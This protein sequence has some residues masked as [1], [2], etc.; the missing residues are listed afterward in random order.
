M[1]NLKSLLSNRLSLTQ[2]SS[3]ILSAFNK[4]RFANVSEM[5]AVTNH[6]DGEEYCT[7]KT[8]WV[9]TSTATPFSVNDGLYLKA[10]GD[11]YLSDF[12]DGVLS[13]G[14]MVSSAHT[15][16]THTNT[17]NRLV[18]DG[19]EVLTFTS[20]YSFEI[21]VGL[22]SWYCSQC[23]ILNWSSTPTAGYSVCVRGR[24]T[25]SQMGSIY[26]TI[27]NRMNHCPIEGFQI[28]TYSSAGVCIHTGDGL[29]IGNSNSQSSLTNAWQSSRFVIKRVSVYDFD[30]CMA[31]YP[32]VY[33]IELDHCHTMGGS[34]T[35]PLDAYNT[36]FGE[37]IKISHCFVADNHQ[38]KS[39]GEMG[40]VNLRSGEWEFDGGSF[41]NMRVTVDRSAV[42]RM[43]KP[44]FENPSSTAKNKR[45]LEVIGEHA[46]CVLDNPMIVIRDTPI[47]SNLFWAVEG[48][49]DA[50]AAEGHREH[51]YP[52]SAGLV[53]ISPQFQSRNQ[54]RPDMAGIIGTAL[55]VTYESDLSPALVGGGGRVYCV[56]GCYINSLYYSF[57]P[58]LIAPNLVGASLNNWDFS[59]GDVGSAPK[60]WI[61]DGA[62]SDPI[63]GSNSASA[64]IVDSESW[65]GGRCMRT[66][67]DYNGGVT[68]HSSF[69]YQDQLCSAG[70][71]FL[72]LA[73]VKWR[74]VDPNGDGNVS[75][76]IQVAI[77]FLDENKNVI[78]DA[79]WSEHWNVIGSSTSESIKGFL[80]EKTQIRYDTNGWQT[81]R[82]VAAAPDGTRYA[83]IGLVSYSS[84]D[85]AEKKIYTYWDQVCGNII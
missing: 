45:F 36:D 56:G 8:T 51:R 9:V 73:K 4:S 85:S 24:Y 72:A 42:V 6:I 48:S 62:Q 74:C 81:A 82:L 83:R 33:A 44:H 75:G 76:Y 11:V 79:S 21:I 43:S 15:Y 16:I 41:D 80:E 2:L 13:H 17:R 84:S 69:V 64:V 63:N 29:R 46:Y 12:D 58:M 54:Y 28:G 53:F 70:Q 27:M 22:G 77:N 31:F 68:W 57:I 7:G 10:V 14:A 40:R 49:F 5:L 23:C 25:V 3:S 59:K 52:Y 67:V 66:I 78:P 26:T 18:F 61:D 34:W 37:N 38:R 32:G 19:Y 71:L 60:Y 39:D 35:T 1:I 20:A 30:N 55:G 50:N 65:S 47:Y